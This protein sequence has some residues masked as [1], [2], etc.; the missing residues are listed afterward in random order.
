MSF[1]SQRR[2]EQ[3][4]FKKVVQK[5]TLAVRRRA[6]EK[7]ALVVAGERGR[8]LA[9]RPSFG[10]RVAQRAKTAYQTTRPTR[11]QPI[12]RTYKRKP[13]RRTMRRA[14]VQRKQQAPQRSIIEDLI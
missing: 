14:S 9:R 2:K 11:R 6:Y 12:R 3:R 1:R 5:R 8:E 13:V 4:A 7:E 10:R